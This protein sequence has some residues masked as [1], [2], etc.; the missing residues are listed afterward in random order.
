MITVQ[1]IIFIR[2]GTLSKAV[3]LYLYYFKS[4]LLYYNVSGTNIFR[5]YK[6]RQVVLLHHYN[7]LY[8]IEETLIKLMA[9]SRWLNIQ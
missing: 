1:V 7:S 2:T 5:Q 4:S 9:E 6:H 3:I 8:N